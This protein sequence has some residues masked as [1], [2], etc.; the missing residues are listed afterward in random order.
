MSIVMIICLIL[1][2]VCGMVVSA[3]TCARNVKKEWGKWQSE[4][5]RRS[6]K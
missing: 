4:K 3:V 5:A 6:S 1:A 2:C